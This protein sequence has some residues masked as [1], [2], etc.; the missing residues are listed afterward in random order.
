M[1]TYAYGVEF[2]QVWAE[3]R[4]TDEPIARYFTTQSQDQIL[5]D[6]SRLGWT[7]E[8]M[9]SWGD[10]RHWLRIEMTATPAE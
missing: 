8:E 5:L 2:G 9:E 10:D 7:V 6:P 1:T 3:M 4:A